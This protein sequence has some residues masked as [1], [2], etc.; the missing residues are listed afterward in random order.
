M[1]RGITT[2]GANQELNQTKVIRFACPF[3]EKKIY[4]ITSGYDLF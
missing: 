2:G 4:L 1:A 3:V